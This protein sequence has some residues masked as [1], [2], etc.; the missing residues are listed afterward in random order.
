MGTTRAQIAASLKQHGLC[1]QDVPDSDMAMLDRLMEAMGRSYMPDRW[2]E[3]REFGFNTDTNVALEKAG[4]HTRAEL[5]TCTF[6]QLRDDRKLPVAAC[7]DIRDKLRAR[8]LHL[9]RR[10]LRK[11]TD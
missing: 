3:F 8:N 5:L 10:A 6:K 11:A 1:W 9:P 2:A 4:I 7:N